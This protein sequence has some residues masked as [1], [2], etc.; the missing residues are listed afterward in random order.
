M[1][2]RSTGNLTGS[3]ILGNGSQLTGINAGATISNDTSTNSTFYPV[4][5]N[6]T[7]GTMLN[8]FVSNTKLTFNP[9]TGD[10]GATNF[11]SLSDEN[12][13]TDIETIVEA[14]ELVMHLRG[15][16]F[17][18]KDNGKSS[19]GLIAQEVEKVIPEVVTTSEDGTKSIS[20]GSIVGLLVEVVKNHEQ[21][22]QVLEKSKKS[23]K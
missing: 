9:S 12:K 10:L 6:A 8:A 11:N 1:L 2:F 20:Y 19:M 13:K 21:R 17:R 4:V 22:L 15:V 3:Y 18:W 14:I 16:F 23:R 7:S 5:A